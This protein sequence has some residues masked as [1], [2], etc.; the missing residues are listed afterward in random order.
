MTNPT[1]D[2]MAAALELAGPLDEDCPCGNGGK[3]NCDDCSSDLIARALDAHTAA[4]RAKLERAERERD[5]ALAQVS[6]I[7][8]RNAQREEQERRQVVDQLA[9]ADAR[10]RAALELF[11]LHDAD[12]QA[13]QE[14]PYDSWSHALIEANRT[15]RALMEA[16]DAT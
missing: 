2:A 6:E 16:D 7:I 11:R 10:V 13:L 4:L 12:Y 14:E 15:L 9:T 5:E 1:P 3:Y 8:S